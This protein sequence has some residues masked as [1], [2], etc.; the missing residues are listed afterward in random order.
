[1]AGP[2]KQIILTKEEWLKS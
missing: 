2:G 1:V